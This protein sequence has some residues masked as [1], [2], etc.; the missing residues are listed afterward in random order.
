MPKRLTPATV[1]LLY[2]VF[3]ALWVV[4]SGYILTLAIHDQVLL[5]R[6]ELTKGLVFVAI[7]GGL[8]YLLL[9]EW[10]GPLEEV[11]A[12]Q[13]DVIPPTPGVARLILLFIVLA[14]ITPM[15]GLLI[16]RLD[17]PRIEQEA[18]ANLETVAQLKSE[19]IES[20]LGERHGDSI[21]LAADEDFAG[22]IDQFVHEQRTT[23]LSKLILD[24]FDN[25][26]TSYGYDSI[27]LLN[28]S[29]KP[30]LIRGGEDDDTAALQKQ[31]G[32][33]LASHQVER[34]DFF[35]NAKGTNLMAHEIEKNKDGDDIKVSSF[36]AAEARSRLHLEAKD[37][38]EVMLA[39]AAK[40]SDMTLLIDG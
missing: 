12:V 1:V 15:V 37:V 32:H 14:L 11:T 36:L 17:S 27:L 35:R 29:G 40:D 10:R 33:A 13:S 2:V 30:L 3:A 9:R 25:L 21:A 20:W 22:R 34:G 8:L 7:T 39:V 16:T 6:I 5:K 31:V 19:Q 23:K 18:Y 26:R 28:S 4:T 38:L 24:R